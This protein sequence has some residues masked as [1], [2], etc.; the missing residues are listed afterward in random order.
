MKVLKMLVRLPAAGRNFIYFHYEIIC[1][2]EPSNERVRN[3][4]L[5]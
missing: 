5:G 2:F 1:H 3:L 4:K